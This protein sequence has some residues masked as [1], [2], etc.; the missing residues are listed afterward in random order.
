[1]LGAVYHH[2]GDSWKWLA[3][4]LLR[5]GTVLQQHFQGLQMVFLFTGSRSP[6]NLC[7]SQVTLKT[8]ESGIALA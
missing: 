1:M 6:P 3:K 8:L 7:I 5:G 4:L 2:L